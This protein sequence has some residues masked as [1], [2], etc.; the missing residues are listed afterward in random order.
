MD[1]SQL[2]RAAPGAEF[3][4]SVAF[5]VLQ[6]VCEL[7]SRKS[8]SEGMRQ[9]QQLLRDHF[10]RLDAQV[11]DQT[12]QV[13]DP[14]SG[15]L[16][17]MNNLCV[18]WHPERKKRILICCHYDTRPFPDRDKQN[19]QGLFLGAND[20]ASGVGLL[21]ELG[22]HISSLDGKWGVDFVFF[23]GEELVYV[24]G[25]DPMFLGSEYFARQYASQGWDVRYQYAVLI[26]MIA[27]R[28][29][30]IYFE[31]NSMKAASRICKSIWSVARELKVSEFIAKEKHQIRDDHLPLIDIA[32]IPTCDIIDFDYPNEQRP[33]EYWHT[34]EDT[35]ENCSAESLGKVG[36]VLLEWLRQLQKL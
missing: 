10:R 17:P 28:D 15:I 3:D 1:W 5:Q 34:L 4:S 2:T 32:R 24:A 23:D 11:Y 19:P 26:D 8:G 25:R 14:A 27:D 21:V 13:R 18:R 29:L 36:T 9:Q 16:V 33:N 12:F 35:P 6:S 20:G 31:K 22:R 30:Q 7:G